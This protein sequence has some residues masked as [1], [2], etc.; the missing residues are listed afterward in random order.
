MTDAPDPGAR[1]RPAYGEYATPE[2]QRARIRQPDARQAEPA[3]TPAPAPVVSEPIAA[4]ASAERT[5]PRD[6]IVTLILLAIGAANVLTSVFSYLD[7][8][9][10]I[11]QAMETLGIP[12]E[13]SSFAAARTWGAIAAV[14][15]VAGY[16]LTV[17]WALSRMRARRLSWWI[18]IVGAVV[19]MLVVTICLTVPIMGDPAFV[20]YLD[21]MG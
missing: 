17:V 10:V 18:P 21:S 14:I 7:L 2:E 3:A 15:L 13:F 11:Q 9:P 12:G 6:R 8:A 20:E 19:T 5:P 16:V 1:P 4:A